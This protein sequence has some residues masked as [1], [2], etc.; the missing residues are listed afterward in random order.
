[1]VSAALA[2]V[3]AISAALGI[4][5]GPPVQQ[6][7]LLPYAIDQMYVEAEQ[8]TGEPFL[9]TIWLSGPANTEVGDVLRPD[10][11]EIRPLDRQGSPFRPIFR[12]VDG[13]SF[14]A[15]V[16]FDRHGQWQLVMYPDLT[17]AERASLP[18]DVPTETIL[19][20]TNPPAGWVGPALLAVLAAA[21]FA[22]ALG[23]RKRTGPPKKKLAPTTG[24]DTWWTGG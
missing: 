21:L 23:G 14:E 18:G 20:V 19:T 2:L 12:R 24:G 9:I 5:A 16:T 13:H 8:E 7:P 4:T 10:P 17:A 1:M 6:P 3:V 15:E 11:I 22:V